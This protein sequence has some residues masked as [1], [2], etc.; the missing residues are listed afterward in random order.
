MDGTTKQSTKAAS[1]SRN[2]KRKKRA[3]SDIMKSEQWF[4]MTSF[5]DGKSKSLMK[6]N[7]EDVILCGW[8]PPDM[9]CAVCLVPPSVTHEQG[10]ALQKMI[11]ANVRKPVLVLTSNT[12]LV[13]LK[14][15]SDAYAAK[16]MQGDEGD[17]QIIQVSASGEVS[18]EEGIDVRAENSEGHEEDLRFP[19]ANGGI[20]TTEEEQ[21]TERSSDDDETVGGSSE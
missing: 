19:S 5:F 15:V 20:D 18:E 21:S 9:D 6:V 4:K 16:V 1:G 8:V 12:Q 3:K 2:R 11:E 17:G 10:L 14:P 13:R 7:E